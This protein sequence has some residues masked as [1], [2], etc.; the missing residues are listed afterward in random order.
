[1]ALEPITQQVSD[2]YKAIATGEQRCSPCTPSF[3]PEEVLVSYGGPT[4]RLLHS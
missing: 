1:M 4:L 3:I 2:C